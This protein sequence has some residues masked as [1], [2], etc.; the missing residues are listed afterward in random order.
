M[1]QRPVESSGAQEILLLQRL[2]S[3]GNRPT[4]LYLASFQDAETNPGG[5]KALGKESTPKK[6]GIATV[7][8]CC[9]T[10]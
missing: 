9:N 5:S 8:L 1:L 6:T 3:W 2:S 7:S 10:S 4:P